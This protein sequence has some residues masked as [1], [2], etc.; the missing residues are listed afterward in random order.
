MMIILVVFHEI[1]TIS[2]PI[3][4]MR[5][6]LPVK[7]DYTINLRSMWEFLNCTKNILDAA[8]SSK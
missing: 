1:C 5:E 3:Y 4:T 7:F 6:L 2:S 8:P